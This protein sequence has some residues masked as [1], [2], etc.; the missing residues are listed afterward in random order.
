MRLFVF[1]T[2]ALLWW[3]PPRVIAQTSRPTTAKTN[4]PI[5]QDYR[6]AS[7]QQALRIPFETGNNLILVQ[8]RVNNSE[9]LWFI[10]DT[11]A[12]YTFIKQRR[13]QPLGLK[14]SQN[15][16]EFEG[17]PFAKG[18][19]LSL[20]G[21]ELLNQTVVAA[22]TALLEPNL[23]RAVDGVLG[24]NVFTDFVVEIDYLAR[25]LNLYQ[26]AS[27]RYKG[28]GIVFPITIEDNTP[29]VHARIVQ[30]D[31]KSTEGKFMID[32]GA[33]NALNIFGRFDNSHHISASLPRLLQS[34]GVGASG[35]TTARVGRLNRIQL[36]RFVIKT[37]VVSFGG[38]SPDDIGDGEIGAE[39]LRR[40]RVVV[41]YTRRRIILEPNKQFTEAFEASL[42]GAAI[43]GEGADYKTFKVRAVL[44]NS[45]AAEAGLRPGDIIVAINGKAATEFTL[46]QLRQ[47]FRQPGREFL[48][49][50][51]HGDET[52]QVKIKLRRLI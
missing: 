19:S 27:Y 30:P 4:I 15:K 25:Q 41:D 9:P 21:V 50:I 17:Q 16:E 6:F 24:Y 29:F 11:G 14:L 49:N 1:A 39:L 44:E 52:Q 28:A 20:Q 42:S 46:E 10:L 2:T 48:L 35:E 23:G 47:M 45:P 37:P 3:L 51:K 18:V 33:N 12:S 43:T 7:G 36:G 8:V 31:N 5:A 22:P 32:T 40:F 13:A 26:A 34:R 38:G